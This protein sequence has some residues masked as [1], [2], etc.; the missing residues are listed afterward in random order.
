MSTQQ[1]PF[2][3]QHGHYRDPLMSLELASD[4]PVTVIAVSGE[5]DMSNT[6]LFAEFAEHVVRDQPLRLVLDLA[7]VTFF[8][9]DGISALLRIRRA[10]M[11]GAG[12]LV[13]RDPSPITLRV[14]TVTG[15]CHEF[16]IHAGASVA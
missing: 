14:L 13:L 11:A 5:L 12:Q 7:K 1:K 15:A 8:C 10:V 4:G 9:A 2:A 3:L 16:A 6:H